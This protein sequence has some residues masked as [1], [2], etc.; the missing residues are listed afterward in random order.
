MNLEQIDEVDTEKM[1]RV[2]DKWYEIAKQSYEKKFSR[3]NFKE[4][5]HVV[6]VGMGG[7]GTIGDIFS[8]ILSKKKYSYNGSERLSSTRNC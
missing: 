6:F 7:S 3:P 2:Y 4:I 1:Y 5:D 8:S